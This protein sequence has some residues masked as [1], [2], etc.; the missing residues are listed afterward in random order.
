[1]RQICYVTA[2]DAQLKHL[3]ARAKEEEGMGSRAT[4][5]VAGAAVPPGP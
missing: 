2:T 4:T 5:L 3:I 1:M